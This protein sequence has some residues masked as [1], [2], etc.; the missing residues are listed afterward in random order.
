[1]KSH[2]E[3]SVGYFILEMRGLNGTCVRGDNVG[4]NPGTVE[5]EVATLSEY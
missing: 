4:S 2:K 1:M 3:V 5:N